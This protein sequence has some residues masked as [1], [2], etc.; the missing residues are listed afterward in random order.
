LPNLKIRDKGREFVHQ[1]EGDTATL[2]RA[3]TNTIEIHDAKASKEHCRIDRVGNRW[4]LVDL[5]SKNG[6]KVNGEFCNKA[7][8]AHGDTISIGA[9]QIRVGLEGAARATESA[10]VAAVRA[11][12]AT[13][14][15]A[16]DD[17]D[18][19]D[20]RPP[21]PPRRKSGDAALVWS[22]AILGGVVVL[23]LGGYLL[24]KTG[25]DPYNMEV[26]KRA[27]QLI[28]QGDWEGAQRYLEQHGDPDGAGYRFVEERIREIQTRKQAY[29]KDQAE[30]RARKIVSK[31][32]NK[33]LTYH[34]G[35]S[36]PKE[37]LA[38]VE[39]LKTTYAA[40]EAAAGARDEWPAWFMGNVPERGVD[41]LAGGTQLE[42]DWQKAKEAADGYRKEW[43]FREARETITRF[44]TAREAVLDADTLAEYRRL[45]ESYLDT[46]DRLAASVFSGRQ[47]HA[48]RLIKNKRY[49]Q[50]I[51][52]YREVMEKFGIDEYVRRAQ[53]E[54]VKIEAMKPKGQ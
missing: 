30:Q 6:T 21:P 48:R 3:A 37:I 26:R 49:D 38:L 45:Q 24:K 40:T 34:R 47:N 27:D 8:L 54:I 31:L 51:E 52:V 25:G 44:I 5:E 7:W 17:Y 42:R 23:L 14:P 19:Y 1:I 4:K 53:A 9:A 15:P 16:Q 29:Y 22:L 11:A 18:D 41:R 20:D 13:R 28:E 50:A 39:E 2:G 46:I 35:G 43:R 33:I 36:D 32:G 10:P 12:P